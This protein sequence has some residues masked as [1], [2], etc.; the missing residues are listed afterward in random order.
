[1]RK[2]RKKRNSGRIK[3]AARILFTCAPTQGLSEPYK[4]FKLLSPPRVCLSR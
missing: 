1:V 2:G 3:R 4:C